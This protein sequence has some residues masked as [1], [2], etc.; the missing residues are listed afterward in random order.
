MNATLLRE[1]SRLELGD[2]LRYTACT[3]AYA[4]ELAMQVLEIVRDDRPAWHFELRTDRGDLVIRRIGDREEPAS[5][6][7]MWRDA[8]EAQLRAAFGP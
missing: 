3:K 8:F 5:A 1:L 4:V 6:D 2:E 7:L